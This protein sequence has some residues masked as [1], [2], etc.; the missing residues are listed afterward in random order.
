MQRVFILT[1]LFLLPMVIFGQIESDKGAEILPVYQTFKDTR[2]VNS[3]SV[4]TLKAGELDFRI[5]HRFGDI[6]GDAGGWE[7]FF[8]L[9]NAADVVIGFEYGLT[10]NALIGISRSKGSGPL[11]QNINALLKLKIVTQKT[12]GTP[13]SVAFVGLTSASTMPK[14]DNRGLLS[15]F[16]K[17][18][19]R[20]S[21]HAEMIIGR[22]FSDYF[23]FQATAGIT[24]RNLVPSGDINELPSVGAATRL[25]LSKPF[26][27]L[28]E[29][30]YIFAEDR[31]DVDYYPA[32]GLAL[33]WET[34]GGH[35]FQLNFTN[36]GGMMETDYIPYTTQNF[37]DGEFRFGLTISRLF[38]I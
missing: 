20:F 37:L 29:G 34:G 11:E 26:A 6:A 9:E 21:Y 33:E 35:T 5:G 1:Y 15:F 28:L 17:T 8:G 14:S 24:Y 30:R 2:I 25:Q 10:N 3:H 19:H 38:K 27:I 12:N 18:A 16:E 4:E 23:S 13:F 7:T 31:G 36:S 22:K 32:L